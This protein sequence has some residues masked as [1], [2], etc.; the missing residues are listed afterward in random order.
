MTTDDHKNEGCHCAFQKKNQPQN[1]APRTWKI[2]QFIGNRLS[3]G[4][5]VA[6]QQVKR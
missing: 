6:S 2:N 5:T 3:S 1:P 4:D